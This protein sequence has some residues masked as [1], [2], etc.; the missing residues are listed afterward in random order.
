MLDAAPT[1]G[2]EGPSVAGCSV[3]RLSYLLHVPAERHRHCL[4]LRAEQG[5]KVNG[6][7]LVTRPTGE[8]TAESQPESPCPTSWPSRT[9]SRQRRS[10]RYVACTSPASPPAQRASALRAAELRALRPLPVAGVVSVFLA[11]AS[12]LPPAEP[13]ALPFLNPLMY[14]HLTRNRIPSLNIYADCTVS[15]KHVCLQ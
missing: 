3:Q 15:M 4:C 13:C 10:P 8:L 1:T 12:A 5:P 6:G 7:Q 14:L 11:A 9:P 2:C